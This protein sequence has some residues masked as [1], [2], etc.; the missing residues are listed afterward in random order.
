MKKKMIKPKKV[1]GIN[2]RKMI[3]KLIAMVCVAVST[4]SLLSFSACDQVKVI[5]AYDIAVKNGFQGDEQ[6]WLLSL[7]GANGKDGQS[8][9]INDMYE[10][11]KAEGYDG[12]LLDFM[13]E[14]GI[15]FNLQEDND[16]VTI[17]KN[18][19]SVVNV[20]CGFQKEVKVQVGR[21]TQTKT[22][23]SASAGSGVVVKLE[24]ERGTA[25]VI[26]NYHVIYEAKMNGVSDC[27][28]LY[29]YGARMSFSSG[30]LDK[31]GYL[32]AGATQGN[33]KYGDGIKATFVAGAMD[34]DIALLEV[35]SADLTNSVL[36]QATFGK[37]NEVTVGE[38]VFAIGNAN[39][40]GLSVT[41]GVISVDSETITMNSSDGLQ[42][43]VD[44]RVMRTDAAINHGNSGGGL[45]NAK[46]ELIGIT[47][48][49]SV[50]EET[51]N[52]G[53]ALPITSVKYLLEN[54]WTNRFAPQPGYVKRAW[55]GVETMIE[56]SA[57]FVNDKLQIKETTIVNQVLGTGAASASTDASSCL[58]VGD[59]IKAITVD[60]E[61]VLLTRR[62]YLNDL[63]LKVR[64]GNEVVFSIVRDGVEM[65]VTIAFDNENYFIKYQ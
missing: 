35:N 54:M 19:S 44:Y 29:P 33:T 56:S 57:S 41:N 43:A 42:R 17:H 38:K 55:L 46:G 5:T 14:L 30:D 6:A 36:T 52:M 65:D 59:V 13:K 58:R 7:K 25:Y 2:M 51:D 1:K 10:A 49:K 24:K 20:C 11:A 26:T 45:F 34:Y 27:I 64:L 9:D 40:E 3:K 53:Y 50:E 61:K 16:T 28:W 60:G 23:V 32:D 4:V 37:S 8:L 22:A 62:Y 48:A 47:N 31:D 15:N 18:I 63:M 12:T 39:G 21:Y